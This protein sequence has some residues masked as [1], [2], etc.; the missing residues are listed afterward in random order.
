MDPNSFYFTLKMPGDTRLVGIVR[1]LTTQ[2]A[3]YAN[4]PHETAQRLAHRVAAVA[5]DAIE[6]LYEEHAPIRFRFE[7]DADALEV[8]VSCEVEPASAAPTSTLGGELTIAWSREGTR[9]TCLIRQRR[10]A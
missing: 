10:P 6:T 9:Q 2:A 1:D 8:T 3:S 7:G 4:L 5:E